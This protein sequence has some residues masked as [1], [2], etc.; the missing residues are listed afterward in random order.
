MNVRGVL[1]VE[2]GSVKRYIGKIGPSPLI[3]KLSAGAM[4][5]AL[6]LTEIIG[7]L[8][9][10]APVER[11]QDVPMVGLAV[12]SDKRQPL[13]AHRVLL[14]VQGTGKS[15]L[16]PFGEGADVEMLSYKVTSTKVRCLLSSGENFIGLIGYCGFQGMMTYRLDN[17]T[18]LVLVSAITSAKGAPDSVSA[19]GSIFVATIEHMQKINSD[20]KASLLQSLG[21]EWKSILLDQP[22]EGASSSQPEYWEQPASKLRRLESEPTTPGKARSGR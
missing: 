13:A 9:I 14:L 16:D 2:E 17:D 1:R 8:V 10:P 7:D 12:F 20:E 11:I 4:K 18:A 22:L 3:T 6:G 5:A 19:G 15:K 21:A